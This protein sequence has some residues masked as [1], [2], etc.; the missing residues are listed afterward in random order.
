MKQTSEDQ[1]IGQ[2]FHEARQR[3]ESIAPSF[4]ETLAVAR[5]EKRPAGRRLS[6]WQIACATFALMVFV[7]AALV[8]YKQ[9]SMHPRNDRAS[10]M[11]NDT[12]V[13]HLVKPPAAY[14]SVTPAPPAPGIAALPPRNRPR[15]KSKSSPR[16]SPVAQ[17]PFEIQPSALLSFKWHSPTDFLLRTPGLDMLKAVPRVGDSLIR[18]DG[19]GLDQKN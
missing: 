9:S 19:I 8:Y 14:P 6:A 11:A 2:W 17:P 1:K 7:I 3:D 15:A 16:R 12:A 18:L 5:S 10:D 13:E 4:A